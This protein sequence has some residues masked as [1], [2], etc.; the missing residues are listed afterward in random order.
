MTNHDTAPDMLERVARAI[1]QKAVEL[2]RKWTLDW[3]YLTDE[4][5]NACVELLPIARAAIE[6]MKPATAEMH[7][8]AWLAC[9]RLNSVVEPN[10]TWTAYN[11][12]VFDAMLD[13]ALSHS[14]HRQGGTE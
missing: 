11:A 5:S 12:R 6:A 8:A 14:P 4:D 2:E 10:E 13:A 9:D 3:P 1:G 7:K